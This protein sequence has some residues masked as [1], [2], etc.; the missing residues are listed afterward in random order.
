[1]FEHRYFEDTAVAFLSHPCQPANRALPTVS[2]EFPIRKFACSVSFKSYSYSNVQD[3]LCIRLK[4]SF[5]YAHNK[6][7]FVRVIINRL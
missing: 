5:V 3:Y 7:Q 2:S 1:M 4:I 6:T